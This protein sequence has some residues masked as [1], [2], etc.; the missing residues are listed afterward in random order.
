M[1][2]LLHRGLQGF[3][4]ESLDG[5]GLRHVFAARNAQ[6]L[7][8]LSLSGGRDRSAALQ[9]R[10]VWSD[11]L[12]VAPSRWVV[13]GQT[14]G[15][16]VEAVEA[17]HAGRGATSPAD[18]LADRDGL[19]TCTP[20]LPLYVAVADCSAI[21]LC[22]PGALAVVHGGWRGLAAGIVPQVMALFAAHGLPPQRLQAAV[23][24]CIRAASYEVGPEVAATCPE[25][26]KYPGRGDRWQVDIGAWAAHELR[27]A[28]IAEPA[29]ECST[30][31]TGSD[32]RLFSHRRE[33]EGA[34]RNGLI[35]VLT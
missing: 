11:F 5:C 19:F 27:Q 20:G 2:P 18:V 33:G 35:A 4:F 6:G 22:G 32:P 16:A 26:A 34:G 24:P 29:L 3:R 25:S 31:D 30:L 17:R 13:G 21:L 15:T 9:N 14:H 10:A 1:Q 8:N 23:A 12:G 28:G 7:G